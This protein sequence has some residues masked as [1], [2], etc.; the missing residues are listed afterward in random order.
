MPNMSACARWALLLPVLF[1]A[2]C[3]TA[4]EPAVVEAA[5]PV[6]EIPVVILPETPACALGADAQAIRVAALQQRLM[7]AAYMCDEAASYNAFVLAYRGDLQTSD[8]ALQA[9]FNRLHGLTGNRAYDTFKTQLANNSMLESSGNLAGYC[10][11]SGETFAEAMS[12][13]DKS[14]RT[15]IGSV[16]V[17][18]DDVLACDLVAANA[19]DGAVALDVTAQ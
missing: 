12:V 8:F 3:S 1:F 13:P 4:P 7:V 19:G 16:V 2:A 6:A 17:P 11:R 14:L 5:P 18:A 10:T 9:F 15:F